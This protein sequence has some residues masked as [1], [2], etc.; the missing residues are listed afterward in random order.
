MKIECKRNGTRYD[1]KPKCLLHHKGITYL[2]ESQ[3]ISISGVLI[4][5]PELPENVIEPGDTCGL[6]LCTD[7]AVNSFEYT[8]RVIRLDSNGIALNFL[9]SIF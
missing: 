3:N 9:G 1:Y 6:S 8:S 4:S 7:P 5:A 2:C